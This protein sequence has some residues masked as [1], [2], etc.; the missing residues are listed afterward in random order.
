[1]AVS[2]FSSAVTALAGHPDSV[3]NRTD[4]YWT[5]L[6]SGGPA[7]SWSTRGNLGALDERWL[8]QRWSM[9]EAAAKVLGG[10]ALRQRRLSVLAAIGM[11]RTLTDQQLRA[12]AGLRPEPYGRDDMA[13][14]FMA[15]LCA[16][17]QFVLPR[18]VAA[19]SLWRAIDDR[20]TQKF[21]S[22]LWY[23]EWLSVTAGQPWKRGPQHDRHNLLAVEVCLR[24]AEMCSVGGAV[25]ENVATL[26]NLTPAAP[27]TSQGAA[28]GVIVRNDGLR[29]AIELTVGSRGS[30]ER[31][32]ERWLRAFG[33]TDFDRGGTIVL[34]VEA[35]KPNERGGGSARER[36]KMREAISDVLSAMPGARARG[37]R[38]RIGIVGWQEWFPEPGVY[39][40]SFLRLEVLR[41]TGRGQEVWESASLLSTTDVPFNPPD[42]GAI[43]D[44]MKW[45][46][47]LGGT[48]HWLR[49]PSS[50][51]EPIN[52]AIETAK[53]SA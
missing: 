39:D 23:H 51:D 32:P 8:N 40:R 16:R 3:C 21:L 25:G 2:P 48:P 5:E 49:E 38:E 29:I 26:R 42:P 7:A 12:I 37:L 15:G 9:E 20:W 19:P 17:G 11:W 24:V 28:D 47:W 45:L 31:K 27:V 46:G 44:Q 10:S 35:G 6:Y 33:D 53:A 1:M 36:W 43:A 14:L 13:L 50:V 22:R 30:F 52:L 18:G 34:F 41:P 4:P